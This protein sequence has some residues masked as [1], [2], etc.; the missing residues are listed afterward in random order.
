MSVVI[1]LF[2]RFLYI[3][4]DVFFI[5]IFSASFI[6]YSLFLFFFSLKKDFL[7]NFRRSLALSVFF[8][9]LSVFRHDLCDNINTY[10][11]LSLIRLHPPSTIHNIRLPF[12]YL[13]TLSLSFFFTFLN[14][15]FLQIRATAVALT[16]LNTG[17]LSVGKIARTKR[18]HANYYTR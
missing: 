6:Y 13:L 18:T 12:T 15:F 10:Q 2:I 16:I 5:W 8:Y 9:F 3:E 7:I 1:I 4:T 11:R 17:F 14:F